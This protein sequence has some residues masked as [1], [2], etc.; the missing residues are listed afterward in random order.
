MAGEGFVKWV[1]TLVKREGFVIFVLKWTVPSSLIQW[2]SLR[3][4]Y[5]HCSCSGDGKVTWLAMDLLCIWF[6]AL[7]HHLR[8]QFEEAYS[9][10]FNCMLEVIA[11]FLSSLYHWFSGKLWYLPT[12]GCWRYHSLTLKLRYVAGFCVVACH[13]WM[14]LYCKMR[15]YFF[16]Y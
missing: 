6:E 9:K 16:M 12:Q 14:G 7:R 8:N 3:L 15:M 2:L 1:I 10:M 11:G 13:N 4:L 5:L